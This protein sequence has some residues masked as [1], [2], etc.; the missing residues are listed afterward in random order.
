MRDVFLP[1][2]LGIGQSLGGEALKVWLGW[3]ACW[4]L[5]REAPDRVVLPRNRQYN[6]KSALMTGTC[7]YF[8]QS[9][10]CI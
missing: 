6:S 1:A 3:D 10:W 7:T 5:G 2:Y 9:L 4:D 8:S